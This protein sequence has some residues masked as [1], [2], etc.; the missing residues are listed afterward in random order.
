MVS[1]SAEL[2]LFGLCTKFCTEPVNKLD[3]FQ[4]RV[5][6]KMS[7]KYAVIRRIGVKTECSIILVNFEGRFCF[8][9]VFY[10]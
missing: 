4:V 10:D 7:S 3:K 8:R 2:L 9:K 6:K 5:F 1:V